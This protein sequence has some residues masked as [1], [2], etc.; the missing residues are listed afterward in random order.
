MFPCFGKLLEMGGMIGSHE[1]L[2]L[3]VD[4]PQAMVYNMNHLNQRSEP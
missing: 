1:F 2:I 4:F 3:S